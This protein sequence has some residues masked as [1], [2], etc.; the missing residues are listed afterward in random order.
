MNGINTP[1]S[2]KR[3]KKIVVWLFGITGFLVGLAIA[4]AYIYEDDVKAFAVKKL[5]Q[6][7][8]TELVVEEIELTLLEKF[9]YASLDFADVLIKDAW[10]DST[11][12]KDTLIYANHLY[13]QFNVWDL[14]GEEYEVKR[15]AI[16]DGQMNLKIA[17]DGRD[18]FHFWKAGDDTA[19]GSFT[20]ALQ[21]VNLQNTDVRYDNKATLQ[22]YDLQQ[23]DISLTGD[24]AA[25]HFEVSGSATSHVDHF[26]AGDINYVTNKAV[27]LE[28]TLKVNTDEKTYTIEEGKLL[29]EELPL[30]IDGVVQMTEEGSLCDLDVTGEGLDMETIGSILPSPYKEKV[31]GYQFEG[32][33]AFSATIDGLV[34]PKSTPAI[35]AVFDVEHGKL[36]TKETNIQLSKLNLNGRYGN[37]QTESGE[38]LTLNNMRGMLGQGAISGE[39]TVKE[40]ANPSLSTHLNGQFDL[41][42]VHRFFQIDTIE[43]M[44]GLMAVS[45]SFDGKA[46]QLQRFTR[47][48]FQRSQ[49]EGTISI[50]NGSLKLKKQPYAWQQLNGTIE[51][52]NNDALV[53]DLVASAKGSDIKM[54]GVLRNFL[55]W[56][57]LKGEMLAVEAQ[58]QSNQLLLDELL[59]DDGTAASEGNYRIGFPD[60]IQFNLQANVGHLKFN[61]FEAEQ[62]VGVVTLREKI[63]RTERIEL[64]TMDGRFTLSGEVN[65]TADGQFFT[66]CTSNMQQIDVSQCFYQFNNF[67]QN[68]LEDRHLKGKMSAITN[69]AFVFDDQLNIRPETVLSTIDLTIDNGE[70]IEFET[71]TALAD[72]MQGNAIL[73]P[74][75]RVDEMEKEMHHVRFQRLSN[76]IE[77]KDQ[78]VHMPR[79]EIATN[80]MSLFASGTHSFDHHI[81][82]RF[83][84]KLKDVLVKKQP[85]ED[86]GPIA[87]DGTGMRIFLSM[88]GTT[89]DYKIKLDK[90]SR[91]DKIKQDLIAEKQNFKAI[92]KEEFGI[93]K[94]DTSVASTYEEVQHAPEFVIEWEEFEEDTVPEQ[95]EDRPLREIEPERNRPRPPRKHNNSK[96]KKFLQKL[97]EDDGENDAISIQADNNR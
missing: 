82:Y 54:N 91:K 25:S 32:S 10:E 4:L 24:F 34:N 44:Q 47:G 88:K 35:A 30:D 42:D 33:M 50:S 70:L 15:V 94:N 69:L 66:S 37:A 95:K 55:S 76:H 8:N 68:F 20:F 45:V 6:H 13:L 93:F 78:M 38:H 86:F 61:R 53:S 36:T 19:Q 11:M 48:D 74:V 59:T 12:A 89:S 60:N 96:L 51:L 9:P 75:V 67:G 73:R 41:A 84:F 87:D 92:L 62:M 97:E 2:L 46:S 64:N 14:F 18:N 39:L 16:E 52:R 7:L 28:L 23:S 56:V 22:D 17:E 71:F 57:F 65:G 72:Y 85:K 31:A 80:V 79:M 29:I 83:D 90:E 58:V 43:S 21:D 1:P 26:I 63:L 27:D 40:F 81:D 77:I 49:A 3:L 5:N